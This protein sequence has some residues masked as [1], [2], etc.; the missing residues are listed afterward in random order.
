METLVEGAV[1]QALR[2]GGGEA[3][4]P[5]VAACAERMA[6]LFMGLRANVPGRESDLDFYAESVRDLW[7]A[8]RPLADAAGRV[9]LLERFPEL[10]PNEEG[11][12]EVA[13]TYAF[14]AVLGL[15]Y[16]LSAHGSGNADDAVSC[17]HAALTAM[18]MLDRNVAGAALLAGER[19][20][21]SLSLGGHAAGLR[22]ASVAAGRERFRVVLGRLPRR[23]RS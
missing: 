22:Q 15:R 18:G 21:Q 1:A 4:R 23:A 7:C 19:R 6:P 16:A 8:D 12:T 20:L 2:D 13:D 3:V 14:F 17:G 10:R 11:I 9:R 5:Y